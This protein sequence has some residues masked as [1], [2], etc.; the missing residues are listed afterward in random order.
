MRR[1]LWWVYISALFVS[2]LHSQNITGGWQGIIKG[3]GLRIVLHLDQA[4]EWYLE[5]HVL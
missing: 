4:G 3:Q 5:R 1:F 2:H